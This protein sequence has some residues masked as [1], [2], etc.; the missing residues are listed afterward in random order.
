M[1]RGGG[2]W[3]F[4]PFWN[5]F[6]A[7]AASPAADLSGRRGPGM[8]SPPSSER[9]SERLTDLTV[10]HVTAESWVKGTRQRVACLWWSAFSNN[11]NNKRPNKSPG[12]SNRDTPVQIYLGH[13][14][15][16]TEWW[17]QANAGPWCQSWSGAIVGSVNDGRGA[18]KSNK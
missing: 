13:K 5:G 1:S 3:R 7:T 10:W 15:R 9:F 12:R 11:G 16:N 14:Q 2:R 4:W 8:A 17:C 18:E 6:C